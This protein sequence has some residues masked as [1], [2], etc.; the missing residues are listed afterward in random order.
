MP[1]KYL[2]GL[3]FSC[4]SRRQNALQRAVACSPACLFPLHRESFVLYL[5][6]IYLPDYLTLW[7]IRCR[8]F[9]LACLVN[10]S[11]FPKEL[12][13]ARGGYACRQPRH[14]PGQLAADSISPAVLPGSM[15]RCLLCCSL[16]SAC[17]SGGGEGISQSHA[18]CWE[19]RWSRV[20]MYSQ[21][22][23]QLKA[24]AGQ[25]SAPIYLLHLLTPSSLKEQVMTEGW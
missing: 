4:W 8:T 3:R 9:R 23:P 15:V 25:S 7:K 13:A 12:G 19:C 2:W 17:A 1:S 18:V 5:K 14:P 6:V 24:S 22:F 11:V 10:K 20:P 16:S 21:G